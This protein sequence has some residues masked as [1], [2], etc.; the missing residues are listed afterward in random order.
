MHPNHLLPSSERRRG[1]KWDVLDLEPTAETDDRW[2][3][4]EVAL[5]GGDSS[6]SV[7]G[8][9]ELSA[10]GLQCSSGGEELFSADVSDTR[11][12]RAVKERLERWPERW[13]RRWE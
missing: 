3:T 4:S 13:A 7:P 12:F 1:P 6:G 10:V 2:V 8:E 5:G 11:L 9:P